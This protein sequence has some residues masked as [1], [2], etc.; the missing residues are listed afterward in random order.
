MQVDKKVADGAERDAFSRQHSEKLLNT[1]DSLD[2]SGSIK[3]KCKRSKFK[4]DLLKA[5]RDMQRKKRLTF[6]LKRF[7][8]NQLFLR[9][10]IRSR[11]VNRDLKE[12]FLLSGRLHYM[13]D[14]L[15]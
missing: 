9:F 4:T 7:K 6:K 12:R 15:K 13:N 5:K 2:S 8:L 10:K 11:K 14:Y 1:E 3:V